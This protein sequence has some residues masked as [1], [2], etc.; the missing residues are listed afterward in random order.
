LA[1]FPSDTHQL[2]TGTGRPVRYAYLFF[3]V[4]PPGCRHRRPLIYEFRGTPGRTEFTFSEP[5]ISGDARPHNQ[6]G[7]SPWLQP[8][9]VI[10]RSVMRPLRHA[11]HGSLRVLRTTFC[12]R[13]R[14]QHS[15]NESHGAA[16]HQTDDHEQHADGQEHKPPAALRCAGEPGDADNREPCA[17]TEPPADSPGTGSPRM[18]RRTVRIGSACGP[19]PHSHVPTMR[20]HSH[21]RLSPLAGRP[22]PLL[23]LRVLIVRFL[24]IPRPA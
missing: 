19:V 10:G 3:L 22:T 14:H 9:Q 20:P 18:P 8:L 23:T 15:R 7:S 2:D 4:A 6:L 5:I 13:S 21:G 24:A 1:L 16:Q 12:R 17:R 11:N